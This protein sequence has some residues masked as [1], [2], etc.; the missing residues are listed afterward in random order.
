MGTRGRRLRLLDEQPPELVVHEESG[1]CP[2]LTTQEAC[3][4]MRLPVRPLTPAE[5]GQ[6]LRAG[7]RRQGILLYRP[8]CAACVACEAIRLDVN[9]FTGS[10]SQRR[11]AE[12]ASRVLQVE[13]GEPIC[14]DRRVEL[15]NLHK[16]GRQLV[17]DEGGPIDAAGYQA[18]LVDSCTQS[19]ELR[20]LL[21]DELVGVALVDH[22]DDAL[23]AVYTYYDP[24]YQKL[25]IGT[26]SVMR[27]VQ[28]CRELGLRYLYLGLYV[29]G[30]E[31][32]EY[33]ARY[34][35]HERLIGGAWREIP[36]P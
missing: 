4:P 21:D 34:V 20:Y 13:V 32:M 29:S 7:D 5:L 22:G 8:N 31:A 33:K 24:A 9:S 36:R 23:S 14:S 26:F 28:L 16:I 25:G 17:A 6:R 11:T 10:R 3:L 27:Q 30:C 15:Y 2:Y 19:F 35:P 1:P 12:K 18:F